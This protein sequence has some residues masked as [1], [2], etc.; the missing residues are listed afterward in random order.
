MKKLNVTRLDIPGALLIEPSIFRDQRGLFCETFHAERYAEA[1]L[2]DHFVQDN[3][4]FSVGGTLRGLHYQEPHAQGKL[5]MVLAGAIY[6]VVVDIRRGSPTFGLWRGYD[7]S[8]DNYRQLYVPPGCA[9]GFCVTSGQAA[10]LYKCTDFYSPQDERG[11]I[12]SDPDLSISWPVAEPLLSPKDQAYGTVAATHD[13][14]PRFQP[15]TR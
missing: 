11:I 5:V 6:D 12:W 13:T 4:S 3:F 10:V 9:H 14:L 15:P 1:G 7:L 8:S 2:T